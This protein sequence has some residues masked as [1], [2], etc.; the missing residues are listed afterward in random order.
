MNNRKITIIK[1]PEIFLLV[2]FLVPF[3]FVNAQERGIQPYAENPYYWEFDG[4]PVVLIGASG[5]DNLFQNQDVA[6]ELNIMH[7]IGANYTRCTLSSRDI[8]DDL[9][10]WRTGLR[11]NLNKFNPDYWK[12]LDEFLKLTAER[13]IVVQ[14]EIWDFKD[15]ESSWTKNNPWNP[16]LNNVLTQENTRLKAESYGD[17]AASVHDFFLSVPKLNNDSILL[18]Y[19][20]MFVDQV[21]SISLNYQHVLYCISNQMYPQYSPEWSFFWATYVKEKGK[22]AGK[23]V[24]VCEMFLGKEFRNK[25]N[26]LSEVYSFFDISQV[27]GLLGKK[28]WDFLQNTRQFI[29]ENPFP[30]NHV[31]IYGGQLGEWTDGP[32]HGVHRF[33]RDLIGG[34]AS[35]NFHHEPEGLG[36]SE[37]A[38]LQVKSAQMLV[39]EFDFFSSVPDVNSE[40]IRLTDKVEAYLTSNAKNDL[41]VYF[42]DGGEVQL[43]LLKFNGNYQVKWL[44][45]EGANWYSKSEISGGKTISIHSPFAGA[46]VA[47]FKKISE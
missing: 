22:T 47:L 16:A 40:I 6:H 18:A 23:N 20:K 13:K 46:W 9:P 17:P 4:K 3:C 38:K 43:N 12:K 28:H 24:Q 45:I 36:I 19:Q 15:F 31:K 1:K 44:N 34:V 35:V 42:P 8:G 7:S 25:K 10:Y 32:N 11:Y 33:W 27:A 21:L 37:R 5:N 41:C 26:E 14:L 29:A 30:I 2:L 39:S